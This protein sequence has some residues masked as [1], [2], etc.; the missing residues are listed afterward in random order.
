MLIVNYLQSQMR[1]W[2]RQ[3][4]RGERCSWWVSVYRQI[5]LPPICPNTQFYSNAVQ[6]SPK[7]CGAVCIPINTDVNTLL[8]RSG[9]GSFA[10]KLHLRP[11]SICSS[12]L[13]LSFSLQSATPPSRC[14]AGGHLCPL[15][16]ATER[17]HLSYDS[18]SSFKTEMW[19]MKR[20]SWQ[21]LS[22]CLWIS[23]PFQD[24]PPSWNG[25]SA[26]FAVNLALSTFQGS[27]RSDISSDLRL[28]QKFTCMNLYGTVFLQCF[29]VHPHWTVIYFCY[30]LVLF[31]KFSLL[32]CG[33]M[34]DGLE[35]EG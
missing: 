25:P 5:H 13:Y 19:T 33:T 6:L 1:G 16:P 20:A 15:Q 11:G 24:L 14:P 4:G 35:P 8:Q 3:G 21:G 22:I 27:R 28:W 29:R 26:P 32:V 31:Y 10:C 18:F 2:V 23:D 12:Y 30:W 34:S 7:M 9:K 17:Q